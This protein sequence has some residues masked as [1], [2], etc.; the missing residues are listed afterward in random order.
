M[1]AAFTAE[2]KARITALLLDTGLRLFTTRGLR[3]TSL[4][5]L[6]APAGIVKSSF[7]VFFDSKEAL[8]LELMTRQMAEVKRRVI[9]EGL[10]RDN[11]TTD[12]LRTFLSATVQ[13]LAT[14]AL[15]RRL[16]T[17]PEELDAVARRLDPSRLAPMTDNPAVA[18]A[19]YI[20]QHHT[21]FIDADPAVVIGVLQ[22]VLLVPMHAER[23]GA[24]LYPPGSRPADRQRLSGTHQ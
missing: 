14:N 7:Y 24:D 8:Y 13:K 6:V 22:A 15:Y 21:E 3:K 19:E 2:E 1:P 23:L 18:L 5:E 12:S 9:H 10:P 17:H 20:T 16:M 4:D 11:D